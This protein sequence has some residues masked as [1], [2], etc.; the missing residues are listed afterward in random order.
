MTPKTTTA[1][2]EVRF[3]A[4]TTVMDATAVLHRLDL[5]LAAGEITVLMGP[6]GSG[7]ST[8]VRHLAGLQPPDSGTV[9]I[10]DQDVWDTSEAELRALRRRMMSVMLGGMSLY[11]SSLFA[12]LTGFENVR[13]GLGVRDIPEERRDELC[14]ARLLEM[15]LEH[16]IDRIPAEMAAH[17]RKRLALARALVVDAP[18]LV[19]DEIE[20]GLDPGHRMRIVRAL[21]AQHERTGAT[22]LVTTHDV[23][24]AREVGGTLAVLCGGRIVA[25]GPARQLLEG[26]QTSRDFDDRFHISELIEPPCLADARATIAAREAA[27]TRTYSIDENVLWIGL[28]GL[29]LI[30]VLVALLTLGPP[31]F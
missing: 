30:A 23:V 17:A 9:T 13:Y 18:L 2:P 10:G 1:A 8:L 26:V 19:L 24:L 12:S 6:S 3:D 15:G 28:A 20:A 5:T 4:V 31:T 14:M 16:E 21:L 25:R 22:M 27:R 29:I 11:E 7:K